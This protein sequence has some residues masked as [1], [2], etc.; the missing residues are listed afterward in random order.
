[1]AIPSPAYWY[2]NYGDGS[3][4]AYYAV[5][6]WT[7]LTVY[8]AGA[9]VRQR[10]APAVGSERIFVCIVAGT[11]L[12]GEPT[13]AI[14][15]GATTA[16][17]AGPTWQECT[18]QAAVNGSLTYTS[19]WTSGPGGVGTGVKGQAVAK[20][21]IIANDAGANYQICTTAGTA[22]S[23]TQPTF[24]STAG[25]TTADNTVTWTS[26]GVVGNFT[27]AFGAPHARLASAF[28]A[29][30]GAAGDIFWVGGNHAETQATT[31]TLTSPGTVAL[32]C[33]VYCVDQ[34]KTSPGTGDLLATA[35][36]STTGSGTEV[37]PCGYLYCRGLILR[38]GAGSTSAFIVV[39]FETI[40]NEDIVL[41][42]CQLV[43]ITTGSGSSSGIYLGHTGNTNGKVGRI[44]LINTTMTF[45]STGQAIY[46]R[47]YMG[48][49]WRNTASALVGT[50]PTT[51]F[52][53]AATTASDI[54]LDGV[55]LS[56]AGSGKTL[57]GFSGQVFAYTTVTL[58]NCK[59]G[60]SVTVSS[61]PAAGSAGG[62]DLI[63]CDSG[64]TSYFQARF[65]YPGTLTQETT[66]VRTS[67]ASDGA[68]PLAWKIVSTANSS[69]LFPFV[70][71]PISVWNNATGSSL[72]ATVEIQSSATLNNDDI[73]LEIEYLGSS[74]TPQA[75]FANNTKAN[76]LAT[77]TALTVSTKTWS[78][79]PST[80][81]KQVLSV[82]FTPQM[83][84]PVIGRV[85]VAKASLTVY[86]DP[87]LNLSATRRSYI[88]APGVYVNEGGRMQVGLHGI[89]EGLAA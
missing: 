83:A 1:M 16:E 46:T 10:V 45:A 43:M 67:A 39:G 47:G 71:F 86:V 56:A 66:I 53:F 23:G 79:A 11:S 31:I 55:D 81:I 72:T 24:S 75:S 61:T 48:I 57:I 89:D 58:M 88:A 8:A 40:A 82:A 51:L 9:I 68:T 80:P 15:K 7:T 74:A 27:T 14:T 35:T 54:L 44:Q 59:L 29:T 42:S 5:A 38:A 17:A 25:T 4:T 32:P 2:V 13:W 41:E 20:G 26:L 34:T 73:W 30:W 70:S 22:G 18:G 52:A 50:I 64:A 19:G 3:T 21:Y 28:A 85:Y 60:A 84:G 6:M 78:G 63:R 49:V 12:V 87:Q 62:V 37:N 76:N 33:A 36:I 69:W 65:R 77:G